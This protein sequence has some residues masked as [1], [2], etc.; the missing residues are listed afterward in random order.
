VPKSL[1]G[2]LEAVG[3]VAAGYDDRPVYWNAAGVATELPPRPGGNGRGQAADIND[4][5]YV[6]GHTRDAGGSSRHAVVWHRTSFYLD[7][8][9]MGQST[10]GLANQSLAHGINNAGDVVGESLVGS[11]FHAFLWRNG[12]FTDLGPGTALDIT[13]SGLILGNAPG[14]IPVLWRGGVRE[15]LPALSG[16]GVAYAHIALAINN[17]GDVVGYAPATKAPYLD[18]AVLWRGGKA[19]NLGR[20]PGGTVS[21]AYGLNDKGQVVGEGN[22]VPDGPMHALRWTAKAGQPAVVELQ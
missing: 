12:Q 8:G 13:T 20:Y 16:A 10:P 22:L 18:T 15:Y 19:I 6:V 1:N 2:S 4:A 21:R 14:F 11:E 17:L 7:L 5:G 9:F 3:Y